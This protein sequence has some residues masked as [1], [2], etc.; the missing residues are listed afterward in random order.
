MKSI[1]KS[2]MTYLPCSRHVL[3]KKLSPV[4]S[5]VLSQAILN[6]D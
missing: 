4:I 2:V 3:N 5:D 6:K 1:N